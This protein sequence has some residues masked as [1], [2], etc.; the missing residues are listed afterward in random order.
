[1]AYLGRQLSLVDFHD[2]ELQNRINRGWSKFFAHK[3]ELCDKA[4]PV[5][6]SLR[7]FEAVVSSSVLYG[8]GSWTMTAARE[9]RLRVAQRRMLRWMI[10]IGRRSSSV[11]EGREEDSSV[12][13]DYDE[14]EEETEEEEK[15][16]RES[17]V[18]WIVNATRVAEGL[19]KKAKVADWVQEQRRR[20]WSWAGHVARRTDMRWS[21]RALYWQPAEG[22][23]AQGGQAMRWED[24]IN[25]FMKVA[26]EAGE[27]E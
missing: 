21:Q 4:Y 1:M 15:E 12:E 11:K 8:S 3:Q 6:D 26:A 24:V 16:E 14:P 27:G 5:H 13:G 7:L 22:Q 18:E 17:W 19:R 10:G 20:K 23:R 25:A 9:Q 2:A